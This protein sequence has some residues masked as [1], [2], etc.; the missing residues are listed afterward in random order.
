MVPDKFCLK[1]QIE[2]LD[3]IDVRGIELK[4]KKLLMDQV[5]QKMNESLLNK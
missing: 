5:Y 4:N 1:I 3:P 2:V